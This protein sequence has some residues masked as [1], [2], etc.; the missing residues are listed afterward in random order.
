MIT[1]VSLSAAD[2]PAVIPILGIN[3]RKPPHNPLLE[4]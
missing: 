3:P 2:V 4:L 1:N